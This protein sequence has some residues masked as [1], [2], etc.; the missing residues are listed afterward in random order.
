[1]GTETVKINNVMP[2]IDK[3]TGNPVI[4][5]KSGDPVYQVWIEGKEDVHESWGDELVAYKGKEVEVDISITQNGKYTNYMVQ[6]V[7]SS[8]GKGGK[9]G[10]KGGA[11]KV[12][13]AEEAAAK[14]PSF[15]AAYMKDI[16]V[17]RIMSDTENKLAINDLMTVWSAGASRIL[18]F[19]R[20]SV[21]SGSSTGQVTPAGDPG[22]ATATGNGAPAGQ[23]QASS[24]GKMMDI[25]GVIVQMKDILINKGR[26][27]E[28]DYQ[29]WIRDFGSEDLASMRMDRKV[30][31]KYQ[32]RKAVDELDA[33]E[34]K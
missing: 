12:D 20:T 15:A 4:G 33:Q 3:K 28:E 27:T 17:A 8:K 9:G 6:L 34:N 5:K 19:L 14:A 10:W 30:S 31:F 7:G 24:G 13:P 16:I 2:K 29:M 22:K 11:N 26:L 1:M 23:K 21:S 32:L 18:Q 25:D